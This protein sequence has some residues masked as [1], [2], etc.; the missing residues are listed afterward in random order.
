MGACGHHYLESHPPCPHATVDGADR[1][2]WHDPKVRKDDAYIPTLLTAADRQADGGLDNFHLVGLHWPE[3]SLPGRSLRLADLRDVVLDVADLSGADLSSANLRRASLKR[4]NLQRACLTG[5]DLSGCNLTGADLREAD[6]TKAILSHTVLSGADLRGANLTGARIDGF[7][8]N[9]GT[10]FQGIRGV[11][12]PVLAGEDDET[13]TCWSPMAAGALAGEDDQT[14]SRLDDPDPVRDAT[15][16]FAVVAAVAKRPR[17]GGNP[18]RE[19]LYLALACVSMV[20]AAGGLAVGLTPRTVVEATPLTTEL[21]QERQ[22]SA[23]YLAR[24]QELEREL[25]SVIDSQEEGQQAAASARGEAAQLAGLLRHERSEAARLREADDRVAL[26]E[27]RI[28]TLVSERDALRIDLQRQARLGTILA[29]GT[30]RLEAQT[31]EQEQRI[32][33]LASTADRAELLAHELA[34]VRAATKHDAAAREDAVARV[35]VLTRE[36]ATTRDDLERYLGR[37]TGTAWQDLLADDGARSPFI[38]VAAGRT[39]ALG[40][41]YALTVRIDVGKRPDTVATSVT[42]QR[43]LG[44]A[45][46][47]VALLLYDR[48]HRILRRLA[49]GFPSIDERTP[50][51]AAQAEIACEQFPAFVRVLVAPTVSTAAR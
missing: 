34:T 1:C 3:A 48:D 24:L 4:A 31:R 27:A 41:A 19:R 47:D 32:A 22:Q 14:F 50:V 16:S 30:R 45:D 51:A 46:P 11:A 21:E 28:A 18:R 29:D 38:P 36:L 37:V 15:R 35:E 44:A 5:A 39:V 49:F 17:T 6:L 8:W 25:A 26:A 12:E 13:R 42:V 23:A 7:L 2:L 33:E 10:R 20:I 9:A 43:P 40:G